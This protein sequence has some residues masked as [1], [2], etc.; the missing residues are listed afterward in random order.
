MTSSSTPS[1]CVKRFADRLRPS[2]PSAAVSRSGVT[3][4]LEQARAVDDARNRGSR[5]VKNYPHPN[6]DVFLAGLQAVGLAAWLVAAPPTEV[7]IVAILACIVAHAVASSVEFEIGPGTVAPTTPVLIAALFLVPPQLV[8]VIAILGTLISATVGRL[9]DHTRRDRLPTLFGSAVHAIG[10]AL[11]FFVAGIGAPR[12][13]DWPVFLLAGLAQLACDASASW[14]LGCYRL[15]LSLGD[16]V[17]PL[18]F[19]YFVDI[20]LLP[21]G[22]L[23]AFIAPR[24]PAALLFLG[25]VVL[26]LTGLQHDRTRELDRAIALA[27]R[28]P[29]TDLPNRSLFD[30]QLEQ[31]LTSPGLTAVL[32]ID[33]DR[34]KEV[35]DTLGH[36]L[37]DELLIEVARRIAPQFPT[38]DMVARLGGDE[39]AAFIDITDQSHALRRVDELLAQIRQPFAIAGLDVDIDAS[40]GIAMADDPTLTAADL[41]RRADVAMYIAKADNAGSAVYASDRDHYSPERLALAGRLRQGITDGELLLHYQPQLDLDTG[42]IVGAE[43]LIRWQHPELGMIPPD[44][45][46]PL[47]E[48]TELIRPLTAFVFQAAIAQTAE[49]RRAG[50]NLRVSINLSPCN[51]REDD[52]VETIERTLA[53]E[54]LPASA[55]VIELTETAVM[56]N[57]TRAIAVMQ[58]LRAAGIRISIDDFGTGHSSLAY[59]T[60]LPNDE[61]KIDRSFVQAMSTDPNAEIIVRAIIDLARS[62]HLGIVAEGV[63]TTE[64]ADTLHHFGCTTA[65]GYLYSRALSAQ[66]LTHLLTKPTYEPP[67]GPT[68]AQLAA[69]TTP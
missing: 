41:L 58:Q 15:G 54:Q 16:L 64:T 22:Y 60:T 38:P 46:I 44:D 42:T 30:E 13:S 62:L 40:I 48:R 18:G 32:L 19:A 27:T 69:T 34:F 50:H 2:R 11:V 63:E 4:A 47:A 68:P 45:F 26:L 53:A 12:A 20:S 66:D 59:L 10:P 31:R 9:R 6:A 24:S 49:W 52:L 28:D 61:L 23:I 7:R 51:L 25:P 17:S 29:L 21:L 55:L 8:P 67:T 1:E 14:F 57:P 5:G 3:A 39:F 35:N 37:G 56:A 36:A 65:Q 43:A 33:L